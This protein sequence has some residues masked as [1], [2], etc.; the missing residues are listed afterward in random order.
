MDAAI[1]GQEGMELALHKTTEIN[2]LVIPAN[3][4]MTVVVGSVKCYSNPE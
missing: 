1:T 3:A 4:G 2:A